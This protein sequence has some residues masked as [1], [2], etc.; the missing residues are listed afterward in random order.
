MPTEHVNQADIERAN[1][2]IEQ[3]QQTEGIEE[4]SSRLKR[5]I[6][7][8]KTER[9]M[10]LHKNMSNKDYIMCQD[11]ITEQILNDAQNFDNFLSPEVFKQIR[12]EKIKVLQKT[13]SA[14]QKDT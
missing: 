8:F 12:A 5:A 1:Q 6:E 2:N 10:S 7:D 13:R 3:K 14:I 11:L 4:A 9:D